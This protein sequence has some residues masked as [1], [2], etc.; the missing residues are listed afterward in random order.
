M[1]SNLC[2]KPE[3]DRSR[4]GA[5]WEHR[6]LLATSFLVGSFKVI[7]TCGILAV[8]FFSS[9]TRRIIKIPLKLLAF[10]FNKP[11]GWSISASNTE[12]NSAVSDYDHKNFTHT[13]VGS[14]KLYKT[15]Q[16]SRAPPPP[17][18]PNLR[19]IL[20]FVR[21]MKICSYCFAYCF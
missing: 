18:L 1:A 21:D 9:F 11:K 14:Q 7:G 15:F 16:I 19:E 5:P 8:F 6:N 4:Q 10:T 12:N 13:A 3:T 2:A 20:T 17:A